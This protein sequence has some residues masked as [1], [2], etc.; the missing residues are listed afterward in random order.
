MVLSLA[1]GKCMTVTIVDESSFPLIL[2]IGN[3]HSY[4]DGI[5]SSV[6]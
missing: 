1:R 4:Y 5:F 3:L 2:T 6:L